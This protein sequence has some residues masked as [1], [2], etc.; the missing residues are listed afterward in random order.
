[1]VM[2]V[3]TANEDSPQQN[4]RRKVQKNGQNQ[5]KLFCTNYLYFCSIRKE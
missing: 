2:V 5:V 4:V 3:L 1:M